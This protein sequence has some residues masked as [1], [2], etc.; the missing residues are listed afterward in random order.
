MVSKKHILN[1][2]LLLFFLLL[3]SLTGNYGGG[4]GF[5]SS[6]SSGGCSGP[7]CASGNGMGMGG[8][9]GSGMGSGSG[10]SGMRKFIFISSRFYQ[11]GR[12][13]RQ[14]HIAFAWVPPFEYLIRNLHFL[15][16]ILKS[17]SF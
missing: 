12:I 4:S 14:I 10:G 13:S 8:G 3:G 17:L 2:I 11:Q 7:F 6:G 1:I 9:G 5:G 15:L 16:C